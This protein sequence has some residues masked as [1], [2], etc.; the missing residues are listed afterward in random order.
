MCTSEECKIPDRTYESRHEWFSHEMQEHRNFWQCIEGCNKTFDSLN[1]FRKHLGDV[2]DMLE[3]NDRMYNIVQSCE[4]HIPMDTRADCPLCGDDQTSL[5]QLRRHL[6][7]HHE[8]LALFA[9]FSHV[10][11]GEDDQDELGNDS[12][13]ELSIASSIQSLDPMIGTCMDF[14][15]K[16]GDLEGSQDALFE[17]MAHCPDF[18]TSTSAM[19]EGSGSPIKSTDNNARNA[20]SDDDDED[21]EFDGNIESTENV[22]FTENPKS[23][24]NP[25]SE[26][27]PAS[28]EDSESEKKF[29][30]EE[31]LESTED[32][33]EQVSRTDTKIDNPSWVQDWNPPRAASS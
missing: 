10:E 18:T 4:Y 32:H 15:A 19:M 25:K 3:N 9:I 2:H 24:E 5:T 8:Q 14:F 23:M 28:G 33:Q 29:E 13:S 22:K 21:S 27:D 7:K 26:E 11:D 12:S 6:G 17:H 30:P 16:F 20:F 31:N 1:T